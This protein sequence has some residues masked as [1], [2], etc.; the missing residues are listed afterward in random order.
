MHPNRL[1]EILEN[2][3][4]GKISVSTAENMLKNF[5]FED[6]G[7]ARVDHHRHLRK[8]H[9]EV[10][11]GPG[12]TNAQIIEIARRIRKSGSD[13]LA[14][15]IEKKQGLAIKR[16]FAAASY[17]PTARMIYIPG[18]RRKKPELK[19]NAMVV[20]CSAGTSDMPV[21]EE[22][23]ITAWAA[24]CVVERVYDV[25]VA[26][27]HRLATGME[28]FQKAGAIVVAAGME[29]ALASVVGGLVDCPVIAVP[30]SIGYGAAFGGIAALLGMLNSCSPGV[31][32]VNIDNGFG[33]GMAA[34]MIAS[35]TK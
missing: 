10:I 33:A 11:Y 16:K 27:L 8:G 26:G 30:T 1:K 3:S 2:L 4:S 21:A 32:V 9:P 20:I 19:A 6:L 31:L 14:S 34:A 28:K 7:F 18:G 24:G 25:G 29:G 15:R 23:A 13:V 22:A 17:F 12:K 35:N 5:A